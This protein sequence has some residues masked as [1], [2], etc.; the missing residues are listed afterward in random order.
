[1]RRAARK[2]HPAIAV[3]A[4]VAL[5]ASCKPQRQQLAL[6]QIRARGELRVVTLNLPTCYYL[7]AQGTEGLEFEL[8]RTFASELGVSLVMYPVANEDAMQAELAAGR[9]DIAAAQLTDTA[10]WSHAGE[11]A[12]PYTRI[13]QLV[14]YQ[15]DGVRP[16]GTRQFESA[17]LAVRAGSAQERIVE[18]LKET[19]PPPAP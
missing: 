3:A 9:A 1:M 11:A 7:G 2:P 14:V 19:V 5:L 12:E 4:A 6:E 16:R 18:R 8:A 17:K 13:P 10:D 15:R